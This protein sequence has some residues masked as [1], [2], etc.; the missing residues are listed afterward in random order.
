MFW[1]PRSSGAAAARPKIPQGF[2][3][4]A[5]GDVHGRADLLDKV[6]SRI[7]T[8]LAKRPANHVFQ[9][10]L[11][12]YVDEGP[13]SR[14]VLDRLVR[15]S[16]NDTVVCLR[17][18]HEAYLSEFLKD[19]NVLE[20]WSQ[21]GALT[22]LASYGVTPSIN[23]SA[24]ER[25]EL[26][27]ALKKAMPPDH[28]RFLEELQTCFICGDYLFVHAGMRPGV[29]LAEQREED[30]LGIGEDFLLHE[31]SFGRTV[32][33][34]HTPVDEPEIRTNRINIDTGAYATG[35]LTCLVLERDEVAFI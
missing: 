15:H 4:Y 24:E 10:F 6:L 21:H 14:G 20:E 13:D 31:G 16:R 2:R 7:E 33:H 27:M 3:V 29:S 26:S 12:N 9:V 23:T 32:V 30:L 17:G 34:G 11:G 28:Q 19:P 1:K 8:D 25:A 18:N 35:R 22:T 5:V